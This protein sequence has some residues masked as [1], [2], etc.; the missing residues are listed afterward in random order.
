MLALAPLA[1]REARAQDDEEQ[2]DAG[3]PE[4][5]EGLAIDR[6]ELEASPRESPRSLLALSGLT[7][8]SPYQSEQI[9]RAVKVLY[10]LGRFENVYVFAKRSGNVVEVKLVLRPRPVVREVT[11]ISSGQ[12]AASE[13][14]A[15]AGL[16]AGDELVLA[17]LP[18]RRQALSTVL[19]RAGYRSA[20]IGLG[21]QRVDQNGGA[22][23]VIRVDE[24]PRTRLR[25]LVIRGRPRRSL[26]RIAARIAVKSGDVLDLSRVEAGV[27]RLIAAYKR[28]G[29]FEAQ[30]KPAE[31]REVRDG[32][33]GEPWADLVLD[34]DSGPKTTVRFDG[35]TLIPHE[36]RDEVVEL[37]RELGATRAALAEARERLLA[38]YERRGHWRAKVEPA[39]RQTP[40]G[41]AQEVLF[42]VHEGLPARVDRLEFPGNTAFDEDLLR[43]TLFQVV[44]ETLGEEFGRPAV[45][46]HT[47]S[48]IVAPGSVPRT[49]PAP[50]PHA[51]DPDP[52][53]LY[54]E[55]AYRA[56][57]D[58]IADLYRA[59]GYQTVEVDPPVP[60]VADDG[61]TMNVRI[62]IRP[63]VRW[64]IGSIAFA[65]NE[66][67]GSGELL[68]IA[69][70]EPGQPLSFDQVEASR[71]AILTHYRNLGH[72]YARIDEELRDVSARGEL[73]TSGL[74][75]T[76]SIAPLDVR[77]VCGR[78]AEEGAEV[79]EVELAFRVRE[80]PVV[81]AREV[82][83]RGTELTR[84][85]LVQ[86]ELTIAEGE[87]LRES[88]LA[89][90]QRNLL[91]LGVFQRVTVR[92]ID[93]DAE[94]PLK[95][96]LVEVREGKHSSFEIGAGAS[97]E[98]GVRV[99]AGYGHNNVFGSALRFQANTKVNVQPFLLLYNKAV[100]ESLE[101]FYADRP[102]EYLAAIGFSYPRILG[103]PR[104]F[105]SG[106]D[107]AVV[108]DNDPTFSED[109]RIVTLTGDYDGFRPMLFGAPRPMTLQ[110]RA[111]FDWTDLKCN[112]DLVVRGR[113]LCGATSDD[114]AR[115][116][117]GTT[118]YTG[119]RPS[120][121]WDLRDDALNPR[122]GVYLEVQPEL[123]FGLNETSPN[124]VNLRTKLNA[125]FPALQSSALALSLVVWRIFPLEDQST[126]PVP[127]N[128]RFFAGGR[129]TIRGYPEQALFPRDA[130]VDPSGVALSPGGLLMVALK[131]EVR[132]PLAGGLD[133][134]VF[135]DIG[136]LFVEPGNFTIDTDSR[137]GVGFGLRYATPIGPLLLDIA[138]PLVRK[139]GDLA[140]VPHFAAVGSF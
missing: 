10:Q 121:S 74:V 76:S 27:Q 138:F 31:I 134:T 110:L 58:A 139:P 123:L 19:E 69:G 117:E 96:V 20:A 18:Q 113:A 22:E 32:V 8:G 3:D 108:R 103:L 127:V 112:P 72:L 21:V 122:A 140:W 1:P 88:D 94:A 130:A 91:R 109:T 25:Q 92:P 68:G 97:T 45:D 46:S 63:G 52:R 61:R 47:V 102:V 14:E 30:V 135:Y 100:R 114:P 43:E 70:I 106:L 99:F 98:E 54:I 85:S 67:L 120:A 42:S 38:R 48:A 36:E 56:G 125:Y 62:E 115:R 87:I 60:I 107:L 89:E 132:F 116:F 126:T 17:S 53:R 13:L 23:V 95:D 39:V 57:A 33:P 55:R 5:L 79:C 104:G 124:H 16:K 80:G 4:R 73:G 15:A 81:R 40:D 11:V 128:R 49:H 84:R 6:I 118:I 2:E 137:Q 82:I 77:Q 119:L 34:I 133:G 101:R 59:G 24:G 37:L 35:I 28:D 83:I 66:V 7:E 65:G 9:R 129:S 90:T 12:V 51:S 41:D 86:G 78:A 50:A 64:V 105:S 93:E 111:A 71:R 29:Y 131:S 75:R 44:D 136:D 26:W